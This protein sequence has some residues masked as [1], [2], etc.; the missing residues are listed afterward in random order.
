M[1]QSPLAYV[2]I[3]LTPSPRN[4]NKKELGIDTNLVEAKELSL[5]N[6]NVQPPQPS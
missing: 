2:I 5:P 1:T 6:R 3:S 4:I